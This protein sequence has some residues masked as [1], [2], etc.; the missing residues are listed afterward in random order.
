MGVVHGRDQDDIASAILAILETGDDALLEQWNDGIEVACGVLGNRS[1]D[2]RSL[3]PIEIRPH[4][5]RFFDYEEKYSES[6]AEEFCPPESLDPAS[7][8][9][10]QESALAIHRALD[11]DGYSRSDFII[12]RTNDTFGQPIFLELNSLPGLTPRSLLP[13]AAAEAGLDF[14]DLC[15]GILRAGLQK[16]ELP[17]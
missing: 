4:A 16:A 14:P 5:G 7:C 6:G 8:Q 15:L 3:M 2:S 9:A 10:I 13:L 1:T 12:P 17:Q 11:C